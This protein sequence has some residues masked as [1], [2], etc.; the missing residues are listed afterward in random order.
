MKVAKAASIITIVAFLSLIYV[1]QYTSLI[2]CGYAI[3][4]SKKA[5]ELLVDRNNDLQYNVS[6][7][8]SSARLDNKFK[9][10]INDHAAMPLD[11]VTVKVRVPVEAEAVVRPVRL[12]VP[13]SNLFLS[14]FSLSN[15]AIAKEV[16]D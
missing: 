2:E 15:E 14:M 7:L 13:V 1:Y 8:E 4:N 6:V 11:S 3:N 9:E 16:N 5:L 10:H 12:P